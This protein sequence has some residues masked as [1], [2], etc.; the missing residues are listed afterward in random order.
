[1]NTFVYSSYYAEVK[2]W[3]QW[4]SSF[5]WG[6]LR[7]YKRRESVHIMFRFRIFSKLKSS[8]IFSAV[9]SEEGPS[10]LLLSPPCVKSCFILLC[11][12]ATKG[13]LYRC[14]MPSDTTITKKTVQE[15]ASGE[16][17]LLLHVVLPHLVIKTNK[18]FACWTQSLAAFILHVEVCPI[19]LL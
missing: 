18:Q 8:S 17:Y 1:M 4:G 7:H 2:I 15:K 10:P 5:L 13:N 11:L 16:I 6:V 14:L 9:S 12:T 19:L 3:W